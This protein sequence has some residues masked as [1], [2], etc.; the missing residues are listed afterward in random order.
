M[1]FG[2]LERH[3]E[4]NE[5][6]RLIHHVVERADHELHSPVIHPIIRFKQFRCHVD[7]SILVEF[8]DSSVGALAPHRRTLHRA[9]SY[10]IQQSVNIDWLLDMP[11]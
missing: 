11:N 8:K 4:R 2:L 7:E 10:L 6:R 1:L 9:H 5:I 3:N